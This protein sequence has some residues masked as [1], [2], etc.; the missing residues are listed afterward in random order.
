MSDEPND[1]TP[2]DTFTLDFLRDGT[3]GDGPGFSVRL[4]EDTA[5]GTFSNLVMVAH[6]PEEF[7]LDFIRMLP[8]MPQGR[9]VSRI[10]LTPS[11]ARRLLHT[12]AEN[13]GRYERTFGDIRDPQP[14]SEEESGGPSFGGFGAGTGGEA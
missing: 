5:E 6:S 2:P 1:D 3:D 8:G 13:V 7:V 11:H 10:V 9:V 12:L 14:L 4:D